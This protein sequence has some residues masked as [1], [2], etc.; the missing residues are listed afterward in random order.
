MFTPGIEVLFGL[1]KIKNEKIIE[2]GGG[3]FFQEME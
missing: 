2:E 1:Y 3:G